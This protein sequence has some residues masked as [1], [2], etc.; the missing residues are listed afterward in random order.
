MATNVVVARRRLA[1]GVRRYRQRSGLTIEELARGL[2]CSA[3]KVSRMETGISGI[4]IQDLAAIVSLVEVD[5][6]ERRD[7]EELVRQ[8]RGREWWQEYMDLFPAGSATFFGL[9]DG[10]TSI[11][12]HSTSVVPGLLQTPDYASALFGAVRGAR[13][14]AWDRRVALRLRRQRLLDRERPPLLTVLLDEAVLHRVIGGPEVMAGQWDHILR[15]VETPGVAVRVIPFTAPAH[16]AEGVAFTVFG[17]DDQDLGP[18]AYAERLG[19]PRFIEEPTEVEIYVAGLGGA[20]RVAAAPE[21]SRELI[22]AFAA[23]SRSAGPA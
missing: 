16:G 15:R 4:R 23:R 3:A 10:A 17:F 5:E 9:E 2:E 13:A 8:A 18:V 21:A 11:R 7:L 20:E 12:V 14:E 22:A 1:Q 19:M 6:A